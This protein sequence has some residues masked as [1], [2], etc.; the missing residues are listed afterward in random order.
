VIS[1]HAAGSLGNIADAAEASEMNEAALDRN[2]RLSFRCRVASVD[3]IHRVILLSKSV[4]DILPQ[5]HQP[6]VFACSGLPFR[7]HFHRILMTKSSFQR[8]E[9]YRYH[10]TSTEQM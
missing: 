9:T 4:C 6:P 5:T 10:A 8:H 3:D 1:D 7:R 2:L